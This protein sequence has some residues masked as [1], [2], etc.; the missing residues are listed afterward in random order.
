MLFLMGIGMR[1]GISQ[2]LQ[3][4]AR[5]QTSQS[6]KWV[7]RLSK[8]IRKPSRANHLIEQQPPLT[9]FD[10]QLGRGAPFSAH[11]YQRHEPAFVGFNHEVKRCSAYLNIVMGLRLLDG[12]LWTDGAVAEMFVRGRPKPKVRPVRLR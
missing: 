12:N 3:G 2:Y 9:K 10:R 6:K 8:A 1:K 7:F 4:L 5:R 11:I